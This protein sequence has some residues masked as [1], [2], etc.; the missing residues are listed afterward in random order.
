MIEFSLIYALAL[1]LFSAFVPGAIFALALLKKGDFSLLEKIIAGA[2][3]GWIAQGTLPFLEFVFLGIKFSS[4]LAI[5]N[6][7]IFYIIAIG[8]FAWRKGYEDLAL[9]NLEEMQKD[10]MKYVVPAFIV[11]IFFLNFWVRIQTLSPVYQELDPYYYQYTVQ[12]IAVQG[13]NPLDDKTAWYPLLSVNHRAAPIMTYMEAAWYALYAQGQ[14]YNNYVLSLASN[15][16]PP[17]AAAFAG[18]FLYLGLRAWY[19]KEYALIASAIA[20]FIPIYLL[21]LTAGEAEV[22][23]YAFFALAMFIGLFLWAQKKQNLLYSALAGFGYFAVAMGSSSEVVAVTI[24]ILFAV[25]NSI[26]LFLMKKDL[27]TFAKMSAVFVA[28]PV[29][30]SALKS[31]FF[32][33]LTYSYAA[34]ALAGLAVVVVLYAIQRIKLDSEMQLYALGVLALGGLALFAFT[35]VG[36]LVKNLAL[37]GLQIAEFTIPLQRT[38]A[39]QG[40]SGSVFEPSL[41]FLGKIFD[42]SPWN[43][44]GIPFIIPSILANVAFA[45]FSGALNFLLGTNLDYSD[46]ENSV[47]MALFFFFFVASIYALYRTVVKKEETPVWFFVMMVLPISLVGLI[48]AKYVIYLGFVLA[49]SIPFIFGELELLIAEAAKLADDSKKQLFTFFVSAGLVILLFQ[50]VVGDVR[51]ENNT[52]NVTGTHL[53][54]EQTSTLAI[55]KAGFGTRFQDDPAALQ[56]KFADL[57]EQMKLKGSADADVCAA[58]KNATDYANAS[59]NN[60]YNYKLCVLSLVGDPFAQGVDT[61]GAAYRC[62]RVTDYWIESME[63]VRY[64]TENDSRI[65]SWWDYGH[66]ENFFG[67]KGAVI[68]N[69]HLSPEMIGQI[70]HDYIIGT[71]G[72]LKRDM[73][74]FDSKYALFDSELILT[75]SSFGGKYG[76]LNYLACAWDNQ[77]DVSKDPGSS[78]C[79][80]EHLWTQVYIPASPSSEDYCDVS[81]GQKG[82]YTYAVKPVDT[83]AGISYQLDKKYC[84]GQT[85]LSNGQNTSALYELDNRSSDGTLKLLRA[86]LKPDFTTQDG[87][88]TV[89]TLLFTKD[90]V[91]M[92]GG[93]AT[94]GW[95][96]RTG[97]FYD[98]NIYNAFVLENLSGFNMVYKTTGG[99]VKIFKIA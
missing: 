82:I 50:G 62:E 24:F 30:A 79:E 18:F 95:D 4:A 57:C 42:H 3:L 93:N 54:L 66:W 94:D 72:E 9:P 87:K 35:P 63:W 45:L 25:L 60:Q 37:S 41:G 2:A 78:A 88:W 55:L 33:Y 56:Q 64:H 59:I 28:F 71:P 58:G 44:I 15:I 20:S 86:F 7:A 11:I 65:T 73:I 23:P 40:T 1:I 21:K 22:Q 80:F 53:V 76:A 85:T 6:A 46:K 83:G 12:Q 34:A 43:I 51:F 98:S 8:F 31:L 19:R 14:Q 17:F 68:R 16:Y 49:A 69:E 92:A 90:K 89:S 99:E 10:P 38:I 96:D 91:W 67:Q 75:G 47:M 81:Y 97:K 84:L 77:T 39:E 27:E 29:A 74:H 52:N 26:T 13:F 61:S 32:G 48:K 5:A 36:A 70:A